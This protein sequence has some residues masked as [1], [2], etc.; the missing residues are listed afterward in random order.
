MTARPVPAAD[1]VVPT[2]RI[3]YGDG[4][5]V[6]ATDADFTFDPGT[7]SNGVLTVNRI[8]DNVT[9]PGGQFVIQGADAT[10]SVPN[11]HSVSITGGAGDVTGGTGGG[12]FLT[13]GSGRVASGG[14]AIDA[15]DAIPGYGGDGG[16]ITVNAGAGDGAGVNG[17]VTFT[18]ASGTSFVLD[19]NYIAFG[20]GTAGFGISVV[21]NAGV[22]NFGAFTAVGTEV[23]QP[24]AAIGLHQALSDLGWREAGSP[25][26]FAL[27]YT[28]TATV[29]NVTINKISGQVNM[30]AL[31]TTLTLTNSTI[32]A[33]SHVML[34]FA[35][36]PGVSTALYAVAAA[37]SCTI[38][39][40]TAL[41]NQ[42]KINFLVVN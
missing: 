30:A 9:A 6:L 31:A 26:A 35:S 33:N 22:L 32:T 20:A 1:P 19:N 36:N 10:V 15:G 40:F 42:T 13:G 21:D 28:N 18:T 5:N 34:T 11:G 37:G 4:T 17:T 23:P 2:T 25:N 12:F 29:G 3:P 14:F 16:S 7:F 24:V 8:I 27:D 38:N 39:A 41:V